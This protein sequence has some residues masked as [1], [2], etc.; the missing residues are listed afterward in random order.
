VIGR[1]IASTF[2]AL[3][4]VTGCG[5]DSSRAQ[6]IASRLVVGVVAYPGVT[7]FCETAPERESVY[8]RMHDERD[9]HCSNESGA[10]GEGFWVSP[11]ATKV[12]LPAQCERYRSHTVLPFCRTIVDAGAFRPMTTDPA[13]S[14]QAYALLRFGDRC[15]AHSVEVVKRIINE[16]DRNE[17]DPIHSAALLYPNEITDDARGNYT[18]LYFCLFRAAPSDADTMSEFPDLGFPYAVFHDFDGEQPGWVIRK[19]WQYSDD[20]NQ[21]GVSNQYVPSVETSEH[22]AEL[23]RMVENPIRGSTADTYFEAARVR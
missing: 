14:A 21:S 10:R 17:N 6:P 3:F 8:F 20:S 13:E 16:D 15:P 1:S 7:T 19:R 12:P 18:K 11:H 5:D 22:A 4:F 2:V 23:A 9:S